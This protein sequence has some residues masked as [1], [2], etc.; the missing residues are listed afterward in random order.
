MT[1]LVPYTLLDSR[2]SYSVVECLIFL[3]IA[4][5]M[6][7][8]LVRNGAP[9]TKGD[10]QS[11]TLDASLV[12]QVVSDRSVG[13]DPMVEERK[14]DSDNVDASVELPCAGGDHVSSAHSQQDFGVQAPPVPKNK[15]VAEAK[16]QVQVILK[17]ALTVGLSIAMFPVKCV[18]WVANLMSISILY[19]ISLV[20][21]APTEPVSQVKRIDASELMSFIRKVP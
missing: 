16:S 9:Q 21:S 2:L 17:H 6:M 4:S 5:Y 13:V 14:A 7:V 20:A 10:G 1:D 18:S 3:A 15:P 8:S 19:C 12:G 11:R